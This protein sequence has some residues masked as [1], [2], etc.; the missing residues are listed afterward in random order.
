MLRKLFNYSYAHLEKKLI[1]L[2]YLFILLLRIIFLF[3]ASFRS[4]YTY[5]T[6]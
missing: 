4:T 5:Q 6:L 3:S 2:F 1:F